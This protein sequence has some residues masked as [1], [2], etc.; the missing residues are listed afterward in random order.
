[1]TQSPAV[2]K[3]AQPY[4]MGLAG[5]PASMVVAIHG[6]DREFPK[7]AAKNM[8]DRSGILPCARSMTLHTLACIIVTAWDCLL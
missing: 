1:M 5:G 8:D 6:M 4:P 7:E 3:G 2:P